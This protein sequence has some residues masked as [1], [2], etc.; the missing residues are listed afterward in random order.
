MGGKD[1]GGRVL[2]KVA[3]CYARYSYVEFSEEKK[4]KKPC[5]KRKKSGGTRTSGVE[6]AVR[7]GTGIKGDV[8]NRRRE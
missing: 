8:N 6:Y 4:V 3:G 1:N 5:Q 2:K 7:V